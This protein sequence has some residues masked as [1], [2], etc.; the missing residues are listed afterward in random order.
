MLRAG[1]QRAFAA[2][3]MLLPEDAAERAAALN[4]IRQVVSAA[5]EPSHE[6]KKRLRQVEVLFD[7]GPAAT[8]AALGGTGCEVASA[9][10]RTRTRRRRRDQT[11]PAAGIAQRLAA[12]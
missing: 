12:T 9:E 1:Q 4:L 5:G 7:A 11:S 6:A 2:I 8:S 10:S 3:P